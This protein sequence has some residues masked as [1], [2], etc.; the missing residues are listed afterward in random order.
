[1]LLALYNYSLSTPLF[2][3]PPTAD[4]AVPGIEPLTSPHAL[5]IA[6]DLGFTRSTRRR[7]F[8]P[9]PATGTTMPF[10]YRLS[11]VI[12]GCLRCVTS[13]FCVY[14][15]CSLL[16]EAVSLLLKQIHRSQMAHHLYAPVRSVKVTG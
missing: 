4:D 6:F 11:P 5:P 8:A 1:M 12:V 14:R 15:V 16:P 2:S 7:L 3:G 10:L 9:S 13:L